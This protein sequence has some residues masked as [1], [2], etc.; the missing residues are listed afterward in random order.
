MAENSVGTATAACPAG[1]RAVSSRFD[2]PGFDLNSVDMS[3]TS[4]S[5]HIGRRAW[6][7]ECQPGFRGRVFP[8]RTQLVYAYCLKDNRA[9][10][11]S[12][13]T[14]RSVPAIR[15]TS[16][17][18]PRQDPCAVSG[19]DSHVSVANR[20][21]AAGPS[22]PTGSTREPAGERLRPTPQPRTSAHMS[23]PS[24]RRSEAGQGLTHEPQSGL[25]FRVSPGYGPAV[26][27]RSCGCRR[28]G[29]QR[30]YR[31]CSILGRWKGDRR[32][33]PSRRASAFL[34]GHCDTRPPACGRAAATVAGPAFSL[35]SRPT[36]SSPRPSS[37]PG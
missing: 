18:S 35:R 17:C 1:Y 6:Q 20:L 37:R 29:G 27:R 16:T 23:A 26:T 9:S 12:R 30:P 8:G 21:S 5:L 32:L 15:S 36:C 22:I 4:A 2:S 24:P 33:V 19:F 28:G 34:A 7:V 13:W 25:S 31:V 3:S 11:R 10:R 14:R